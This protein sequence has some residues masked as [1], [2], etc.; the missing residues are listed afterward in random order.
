MDAVFT[1]NGGTI[2]A[3]ETVQ[4]VYERLKVTT[5]S[6]SNQQPPPFDKDLLVHYKDK[7]YPHLLHSQL[8]LTEKCKVLASLKRMRPPKKKKAKDK[9]KDRQSRRRAQIQAST[10]A[11]L[12]RSNQH[13]WGQ[14]IVSIPPPLA[15]ASISGT[16]SPIIS[17]ATVPELHQ[18]QQ[19]ASDNDDDD[20]DD[21][22]DDDTDDDPD[23]GSSSSSDSGSA[24]ELESQGHAAEG[25]SSKKRMSRD[26]SVE[27]GRTILS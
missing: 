19:H 1:L 27:Q 14:P 13:P 3:N 18:Q 22:D 12:Q 5:T 23:N 15:V 6:A 24:E 8:Y 21:D 9:A 10:H 4:D 26:D 25:V 11:A 7:I 16:T 2:W 20:T 17:T